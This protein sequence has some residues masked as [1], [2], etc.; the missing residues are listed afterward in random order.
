MI[1]LPRSGQFIEDNIVGFKVESVPSTLA[2]FFKQ[3]KQNSW[4][5]IY[6][7]HVTYL[8]IHNMLKYAS[9]ES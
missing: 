5:E 6:V 2:L 9:T 7:V 4:F 1:S 8:Q 3:S